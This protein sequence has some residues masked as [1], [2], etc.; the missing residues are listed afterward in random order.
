MLDVGDFR[1]PN[2]DDLLKRIYDKT[3]KHFAA[4]HCT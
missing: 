2:G 3:R 1:T 4:R